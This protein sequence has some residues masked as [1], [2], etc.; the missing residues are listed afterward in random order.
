MHCASNNFL[1]PL[2]NFKIVNAFQYKA[3]ATEYFYPHVDYNDQ[4]YKAGHTNC[5]YVLCCGYEY[6]N[7]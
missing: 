3:K 2:T 5:I 4:Y 6:Q 7:T 1:F